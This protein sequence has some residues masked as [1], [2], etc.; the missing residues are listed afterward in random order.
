MSSFSDI[1][2]S[3]L[4]S[5]INE[6]YGERHMVEENNAYNFVCPHCGEM[7]TN[8][9]VKP[10][11][12]AYIY[13]DTWNFICYKCTPAHHVMY[14]FKYDFNDVYKRLLFYQSGS[15]SK[16]YAPIEKKR[17]YVEGAYPFKDGELVS[18][19]KVGDKDV[20]RAIDFC[21]SRK[22]RE[23]VYSK[24]YVCK[25]DKR[26]LD[27]NP[28][29]TLK[30]NAVGLPTGNEY[31]NRLIIPYYRFGGKWI[32]FDAR[33][34]S[35]ESKL[36]YRNYAGAKREL[37]NSDFVHFNRPFYILEGAIDSTFVKNSVAVGGLKHFKSFVDENPDIKKYKDNCTIIFD[38]DASGIDDLRSIMPMGFKWF[39]WHGLINDNLNSEKYGEQVKDI[40]EGVLNCSQFRLTSD[41]YVDP[42]FIAERTH[43]AESGITLLN[44]K[45]GKNSLLKKR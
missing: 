37:Y 2:D 1:P 29:G 40:N 25:R 26:F 39:D 7:P 5:A 21:K 6:A 44:L 3:D 28:D 35:K 31:G 38:A 17:V 18:L 10:K 15:K 11:R 9:S 24:W 22:I 8:P 16:S 4:I 34:L 23:A 12:K 20:D 14:E 19:D 33:D 36:R 30:L 45:Y 32:Q 41:G 27:K 42:A 13:K 43:S